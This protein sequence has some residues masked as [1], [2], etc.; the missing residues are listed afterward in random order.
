MV[1]KHILST[2]FLWATA[3]VSSSVYAQNAVTYPSISG[4]NIGQVLTE[5]ININKGNNLLKY[6]LMIQ[7]DLGMMLDERNATNT[8]RLAEYIVTNGV[9]QYEDVDVSCILKPDLSDE[10]YDEYQCVKASV[11]LDS[12]NYDLWVMN[13]NELKCA[14][15]KDYISILIN[16][17]NKPELR[18]LG[19]FIDR[20]LDGNCD[21]GVISYIV[22]DKWK[23]IRYRA[24]DENLP[25]EESDDAPD[26]TLSENREQCQILYKIITDKLLDYYEQK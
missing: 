8:R 23:T 17:K 1:K 12:I 7:S 3:L 9:S 13:I 24:R 22:N 15:E 5:Q 4:S 21:Q 16:V 25:C 6:P 14:P 2:L 19:I 10:P 11:E 20:G 18:N 26:D